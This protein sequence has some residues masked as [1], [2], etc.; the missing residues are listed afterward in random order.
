MNNVPFH[1]KH[2]NEQFR[3]ASI[4]KNAIHT[5]IRIRCSHDSSN[6]FIHLFDPSTSFRKTLIYCQHQPRE[7]AEQLPLSL[8]MRIDHPSIPLHSNI[9]NKCLSSKLSVITIV[10]VLILGFVEVTIK[11]TL[12]CL[13]VKVIYFEVTVI[14]IDLAHSSASTLIFTSYAVNTH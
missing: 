10:V 3:N 11:V 14:N 4:S 7:T 2:L 13:P 1:R 5:N 12:N 6:D 9:E 8:Q